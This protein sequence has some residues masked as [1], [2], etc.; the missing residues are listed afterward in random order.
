MPAGAFGCCDC[1]CDSNGSTTISSDCG[2]NCCC[3]SRTLRICFRLRGLDDAPS[4]VV[5]LALAA[6]CCCCCNDFNC[7]CFLRSG[8]FWRCFFFFTGGCLP[9]FF[10][11][12]GAAVP[13]FCL[14]FFL[15]E[16]TSSFVVSPLLLSSLSFGVAWSGSSFAGTPGTVAA[17][18]SALEE[19]GALS[20]VPFFLFL[21]TRS[22]FVNRALHNGHLFSRSDHFSM[23]PKQK[24]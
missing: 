3:F 18:C 8:G 5:A 15:L 16:T 6:L 21:L 19:D 9:L 17:A 24:R 13:L 4:L 2:C 1:D 20:F 7:C 14:G 23:Q 12:L 22:I 10:F 11:A